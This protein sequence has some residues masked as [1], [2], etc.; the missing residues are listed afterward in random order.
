MTETDLNYSLIQRTIV[1]W[2][3]RDRVGDITEWEWRK[4][5]MSKRNNLDEE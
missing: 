3:L 4:D 2:G 5:M 1:A